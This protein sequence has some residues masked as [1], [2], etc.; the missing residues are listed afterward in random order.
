[1]AHAVGMSSDSIPMSVLQQRQPAAACAQRFDRARLAP[2]QGASNV[3]DLGGY[4]TLDGRHTRHGVLLRA[5]SL[6]GLT[7]SD[8]AWLQSYGVGTVI[9][10]RHEDELQRAPSMFA[11]TTFVTYRH[12][13]VREDDI[14]NSDSRYIAP[15]PKTLDAYYRQVVDCCQSS[16]RTVFDALTAPQALP[17]LFGCTAGK[18][19]T[20]IVAALVLSVAGVPREHVIEDYALTAQHGAATLQRL[21]LEGVAYAERMGLSAAWFESM[22]QCEPAFMANLLAYLDDRLGGPTAYLHAIGVREEQ[23]VR[24]RANLVA[25]A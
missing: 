19:R 7:A 25:N 18:D 14:V 23:L 8:Q 22:L 10:L 12:I 3:R 20:G 24:L 5:D 16:L 6:H 1:M 2:L 4:P 13:P 11:R 21:R 9:D 15:P 17:A